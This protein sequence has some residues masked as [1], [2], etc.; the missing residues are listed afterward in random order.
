MKET[1]AIE[2]CP[3]KF[4]EAGVINGKE[5]TWIPCLT[6]LKTASDQ[7]KSPAGPRQVTHD[8]LGAAADCLDSHLAV[9]SLHWIAA[10]LAGFTKNLTVLTG[11]ML[12]GLRRP[13]LQQCNIPYYVLTALNLEGA[14]LQ[15]DL[16]TV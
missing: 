9:A 15:I 2:I 5:V 10:H 8:F 6:I 7:F 12:H 1:E 14:V 11:A 13:D 16:G 4:T 3:L